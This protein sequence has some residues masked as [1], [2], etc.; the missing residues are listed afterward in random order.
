MPAAPVPPTVRPPGPADDIRVDL[1]TLLASTTRFP[2]PTIV[3]VRR[4][5]AFE[6]DPALVPGAIRRRPEDVGAWAGGLDRW[7]PVVVYCAHGHEVSGRGLDARALEGGLDAWR[8]SGRPTIR[9]R[10]PTRWVTRE[11]P[12]IDRIACP[13]LLRRFVDPD[14]RFDYVPAGEV[15]AHARRTGATPF[16]VPDVEYTHVGARCSFDAFVERHAIRAPGIERLATIVRA[17]DTGALGDAPEAAGLLAASL[18]LSRMI[19]DDQAML[20]L[21]LALYDALYLGCTDASG[22]THGWNPDALRAAR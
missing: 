4:D 7:R 21:G 15:L 13:W 14:A 3:D 22:E 19:A 6:R 5:A 1:A 17:A 12:K 9:Y 10:E 16:D 11:R 18:G 20:G 2:P 8:E